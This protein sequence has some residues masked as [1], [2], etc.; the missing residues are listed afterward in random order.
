MKV[1]VYGSLKRGFGNHGLL[2]RS[3]YLGEDKTRR[4]FSMVSMR[5]FPGVLKFH[6]DANHAPILGEL[7]EV[8]AKTLEMLDRLESNGHFYQR[9]KVR[10]D[11]LGL[12]WMYF[13]LPNRM[14]G[15][16]MDP[17]DGVFLW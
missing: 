12:A 11:K 5:S 2:A 13:L 7:Y 17:V 9:E 3:K 10:L 8:D 14:Y 1:F 6:E 15:R 4:N 16:L